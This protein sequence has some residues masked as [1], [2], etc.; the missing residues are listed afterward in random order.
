MRRY[1][2]VANKTLVGEDVLEGIHGCIADGRCR[3]HILVPATAPARGLTWTEGEAKRQAGDRLR[4]ALAWF[5][6]RGL[7]ATGEVSDAGPM[8]AVADVMRR[9]PF[10]E[11]VLSTFPPGVSRWLKR[12]LPRRLRRAFRLPVHH[13]VGVPPSGVE[14]A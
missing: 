11:I 9:E 4:H 13:V 1:L 10:D 14:A 7:E 5:R 12:D 3:V 8:D 2:V 6:G